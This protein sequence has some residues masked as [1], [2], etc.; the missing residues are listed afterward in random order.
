[1]RSSDTPEPGA[2][3]EATWRVSTPAVARSSRALR[4]LREPF[5]PAILDALS[6]FDGPLKANPTQPA[7]LH[8]IPRGRGEA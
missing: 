2:G 5:Q 4:G 8:R 7:P 1:M 3:S 6:T